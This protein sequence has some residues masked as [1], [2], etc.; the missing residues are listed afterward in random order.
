MSETNGNFNISDDDITP[1][2]EMDRALD[3]ALDGGWVF[4]DGEISAGHKVAVFCYALN[5][6]FFPYALG[7]LVQRD[8]D[9]TLYHAKQSGVIWAGMFSVALLGL[10]LL[11]LFG[12]GLLVWLVG[13]PPLGVLNFL[14]LL[15]ALNEEAKPLPF[16]ETYPQ[17]WLKVRK[18]PSAKRE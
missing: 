11:P 17:E 8:N 1:D 4:D 15:Q 16:L 5:F 2:P 14:G 9:Y 18:A 6:V 3:A 7:P 13:L 12:L 10:L